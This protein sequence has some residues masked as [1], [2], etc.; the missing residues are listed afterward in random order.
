[1]SKTRRRIAALPP[2]AFR[3]AFLFLLIVLVGRA[4]A[5]ADDPQ[6]ADR[7][8]PITVSE[9]A[10]EL[11]RSSLVF[12]GHNDLPWEIRNSFGSSLASA[13][14]DTGQPDMHT[15][16]PRLRAGG[17]G[18]QFWSVYVPVDAGY[19]GTA[20]HDVL[21]QIDLVR[22]MCRAYPETFELALTANDVERIH[23]S[24]RIASLIGMEGGYAIEESLSLLRMFYQ[25]GARYMTLTHSDTLSWA[26]SATDDAQHGGLTEFGEEVVLEMNRLGMLV[27]ISHVSADTMRDALRVSRAPVIASHSSAY[28][29][30]EHS[31]NVPDDVLRG[32]ADNGGVVMVNFFS[33]Y[34]VPESA[35]TMQEM[36]AVRR[37][38]KTEFP[39]EDDYN[40]AWEDWRR[41]HPIEAGTIH[42]VVDHIEH[43][44]RAAGS[45]HVGLGSDYDGVSRLP[46]GLEDVSTYPRITQVLLDRGYSDEDIRKILGLNM[47]RVLREAEE[48]AGDQTNQ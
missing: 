24:G 23:A 12:D 4:P 6:N 9:R 37:R 17:V 22:Q 43:I 27:D 45:D 26:D 3:Q 33:G 28:A 31:R 47:L 30:A 32:I 29:I 35:R 46:F 21:T 8:A 11:H 44:V 36:F 16:I 42:D 48:A 1:M 10:R 39:D 2:P 40:R 34:V 13:H 5:G 18:A 7:H 15:D 19:A 38:L 25:V 20:A 41:E 14:I